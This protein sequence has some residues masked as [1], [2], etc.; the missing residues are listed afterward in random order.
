VT[1]DQI[2]HHLADVGAGLPPGLWNV[3]LYSASNASQ[4]CAP[5]NSCF[6]NTTVW[7]SSPDNSVGSPIAISG[8]YTFQS[9]LAMV[10]PGAKPTT[11][12]TFNLPAYAQQVMQF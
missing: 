11:F 4:S 1:I 9:A 7:P 10:W 8:S 5:L 6:G 12:G 2:A 3:T